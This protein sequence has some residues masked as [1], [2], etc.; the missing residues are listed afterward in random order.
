MVFDQRFKQTLGVSYFTEMI[1]GSNVNGPV[2]K[3]R[4]YVLAILPGLLRDNYAI[5]Q[6]I[7]PETAS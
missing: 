4:H 1:L 5:N 7:K 6:K 3:I 2:N